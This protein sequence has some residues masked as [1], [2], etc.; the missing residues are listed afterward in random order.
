MAQSGTVTFLFTDL[1]G[2]T[3]HLERAGDEAGQ[4]LFRAHHKLMTDAVT[5]AGGQELQWLGD[6][7]LAVFAST[8]DAIR[9]A[10]QVQQTA[11]RPA[12]GTHF[13]IRIGIHVGEAMRRD[14]GYF[15][16]AVVTARRL[17][18]RAQA[19]QILCSKLVA[20]LLSARHAFNFRDAG[21]LDLKG[22]TAPVAA[23]EVVYERND[24]AALLSRTPFVGR[25]TQIK[26]LMAKL[27]SATGSHGSVAMLTGEP[28]IGKT[29]TLEEFSDA[30]RQHGARV[31]RGACYDGEFQPPYGPFAE[32]ISDY[33]REASA[34]ELKTVLGDSA[35]TLARIA[36]SLRRHLGS[37]P[38]PPALEKDE[39]RFRLLDAVAQALIALA[40][41][42]PL[43]LILDDLHWAD[44][45]T[46]AMLGHVAHFVPSYPILLIGAYREGEVGRQHPLSGALAAIR[47]LRDFESISLKGLAG[48][49]VAELLGMIGDKDAPG[50]LVKALSDETEGNPF[51]IREVLLHL[52]EEGRILRDG[53]GWT[54]TL[55]IEELGIPEGVREIIARRIL[56]LS[57]EARRLLS[58]GAAFNGAF[59]FD[60]AAAV[61]GL[62][63]DTAL[64]AADEALDAHLL[65]PGPSSESFDFTHAL[66]RHA[67]YAELNPPR[68][69]RLHRQIAEAM[70]REWGELAS[71]HAAEVAYQ[72]WRGSR[73][74]GAERGVEYAIA[75]AN[76]AEKAYAHDEVVVF[77]RIALELLPPSDPRRRDLM[78]RLG[79]ALTST[80]QAQEAL[81]I[82]RETAAMIAAGA[83]E[84]AVAE[85]YEN[86]ARYMNVAGLTGGAFDLAHEGLDHIGERRDII[87]AS[88]EELNRLREEANDPANP[89]IRLDSAGY[90]QWRSILKRLPQ[91]EVI[92][93]GMEPAFDS[94]EEIMRNPDATPFALT[95]F[96]GEYGRT[97][98]IWE[99][100]AA[101]AERKGRISWAM[102]CWSNVAHCH[103]GLGDIIAAQAAYDRAS[104]FSVREVG[105]SMQYISLLAVRQGLLFATDCGWDEMLL[106]EGPRRLLAQ[107]LPQSRFAIAAFAATAA[108]VNARLGQPDIA[109]RWVGRVPA[110]L[111]AG[112]PFVP[113]YASAACSAAL[114]LWLLNRTDYAE[115]IERSIREKVLAPDFRPTMRDSRLSLGWLSALHGRYEEA[116]DF[117][118]Q[119]RRALDEQGSRIVRAIVDYDEA[120]MYLRRAR[121]GD[122][123]LARPLLDAA[124]GQ[125]KI[126]G[127]TGWIARAAATLAQIDPRP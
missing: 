83:G 57:D 7:V 9:C 34:E 75:A 89:G 70:E 104:A 41:I 51:F 1:V 66:I 108:Y 44:R 77:L 25:V 79:F 95:F 100:E 30:A 11:R 27:D 97:L 21:L 20:D 91:A 61:A 126:I 115:I 123:R 19:G 10:I 110:A 62:D 26:R 54:S 56:R 65:R 16:A 124:L 85:Y 102:N 29:R 76:N 87:W 15:G 33:A 122:G 17:C 98:P 74:S 5:A 71:E 46:V 45:G 39:E 63:E 22:I 60:V 6:G 31:M 93:H 53:E 67:L 37:I 121:N 107:P 73:A 59:S 94:R 118:A 28:G 86:A 35:A 116:S 4:Q 81:K 119:A 92:A 58:V 14:E 2:S 88:L 47:R 90:R 36:P 40:Q 109:L 82:I 68:R 42:A 105:V 55:S 78:T 127:M 64:T 13:E 101:D 50:A 113:L 12:A 43:V 120:L 69:V 49:E 38:D 8:A 48:G 32:A 114:A 52:M 103:L 125:F 84:S 106:A 23:C 24:P 99:R 18:D 96:A 111:E 80:L 117:F 3:E 72:F 112:T